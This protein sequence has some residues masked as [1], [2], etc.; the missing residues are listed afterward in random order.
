M[1]LNVNETEVLI[2]YL[3]HCYSDDCSRISLQE[4]IICCIESIRRV[5]NDDNFARH[6]NLFST[7]LE[8]LEEKLDQIMLDVKR[9]DDSIVFVGMFVTFYMAVNNKNQNVR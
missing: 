5:I 1:K 3:L 2:I 9:T 7:N 4:E 8:Y 6:V